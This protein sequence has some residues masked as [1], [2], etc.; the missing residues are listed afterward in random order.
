MTHR[1]RL[2]SLVLTGLVFLI[3]AV[4]TQGLAEARIPDLPDALKPEAVKAETEY[5]FILV[6]LF[7]P[8][9][10]TCRQMEPYLDLLK[11]KH[12]GKI[13]FKRVDVTLPENEKYLDMFEAAGTPT[14]ILF[15][16]A[17]KP[18][19][20]MNEFISFGVLQAQLGRFT[21]DMPKHGY[22]S[23]P[24]FAKAA[25]NGRF[26]LVAFHPESCGEECRQAQTLL[27]VMG[28]AFNETYDAEGL[29]VITVSS[30]D[31]AVRQFI[32]D[33]GLQADRAY[34][35]FDPE[36]HALYR[37]EGQFDKVA[38]WQYIRALADPNI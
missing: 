12:A 37:Q 38:M 5:R 11:Q 25:D 34:M 32:A 4:L 28:Y 22:P 26:K 36:G 3:S 33:L 31:K 23:L 30:D 21:G 18:V 9:C 15:D 27:D 35:L 17:G 13:A 7:S 29:D 8:Y 6:D 16:K 20:R 24:A 2:R 19:Y 14:Y 10:G 1:T